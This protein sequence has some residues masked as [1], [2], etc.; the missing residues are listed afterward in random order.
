MTEDVEAKIPLS[1]TLRGL[2]LEPL[3]AGT[4]VLGGTVII[5]CLDPE[6]E[7][8]LVDRTVMVSDEELLGAIVVAAHRMT[9]TI[10]NGTYAEVEPGSLVE[11]EEVTGNLPV[12]P[13]PEGWTPM[14]ALLLVRC[15]S[16]GARPKWRVRRSDGWS[17][18]EVLGALLVRR[19][20]LRWDIGESYGMFEEPED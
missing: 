18:E 8:R 1:E 12:F 19:D 17:P 9:A 3:P 13:L 7:Q 10:E 14:D 20:L 15:H 4:S 2:A 5:K 6:G 16:D 11:L